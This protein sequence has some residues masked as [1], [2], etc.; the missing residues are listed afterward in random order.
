[1]AGEAAA[2]RRC[3]QT[4]KLFPRN[5]AVYRLL[6]KAYLLNSQYAEAAD[7]FLRLLSS[8]PDDF[9]AHLGLSLIREK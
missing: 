4:L 5:L 9:T 2:Q 3:Q 8:L 7:I 1:M 6:G